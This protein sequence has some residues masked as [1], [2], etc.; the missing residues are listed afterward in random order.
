MRLLLYRVSKK[1][2]DR[3]DSGMDVVADLRKCNHCIGFHAVI[4]IVGFTPFQHVVTCWIALLTCSY[5]SAAGDEITVTGCVVTGWQAV[6]RDPRTLSDDVFECLQEQ[7][8][9]DCGRYRHHRCQPHVSSDEQANG[10]G[11]CE[12][13]RF[14]GV[15]RRRAA[16]GRWQCAPAAMNTLRWWVLLT[17]RDPLPCFWPVHR[18]ECTL[19][20]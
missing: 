2:S 11:A 10:R 18:C 15:P 8:A 13:P 4:A 9:I 20:G 6:R 14:L 16:A 1:C 3:S 17:S 12:A 7:T 5:R 19:R